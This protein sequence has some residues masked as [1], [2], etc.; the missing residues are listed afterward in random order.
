M[1]NALK[2]ASTSIVVELE[3]YGTGDLDLRVRDDGPG[4]SPADLPQVFERLYVSRASPGRSVGTGIG[5]AI[6]RELA[7]AMGGQAWVDPADGAGT[8]FVVRLPILRAT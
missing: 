7:G 3:S 8:T 6:V 5:L 2:Y 1:E 4:I